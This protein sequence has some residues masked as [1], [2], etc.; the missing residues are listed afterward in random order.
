[1][2]CLNLK[3]KD[4]L[5]Q[6]DPLCILYVRREDKWHEVGRTEQ[7]DNDDSP[8][9]Q[10]KFIVDYFFEERQEVKFEVYDWDKKSEKLTDHDYLGKLKTTLGAIVAARGRQFVA[11]MQKGPSKGG[12]FVIT[13]EEVSTNRDVVR[14][15]L[16]ATGLDKKDTFSKSDPV[17]IISKVTGSG[18]FTP[19]HKTEV[20]NNSLNP[21]W[22][23]FSIS[24]R[25]LCNG[26]YD[27]NLQFE[28][29]DWDSDGK[30]DLIGGFITNLRALSTAT[31]Q[32]KF[33]QCINPKKQSKKNY[34]NSGE[35]FLKYF[36]IERVTSF[37]DYIQAGTNL[38][39]SVAIDFTASN[40]HPR[41]PNSLHF[42]NPKGSNQYTTAI[43]AVGSVIQDYDSDKNFPALG[44]G[45]K[46]PPHGQVSHEF[47]LNLQQDNPFCA[48]VTGILAAYYTSLQHVQ[49]HGPTNFAPIIKHNA[50]LANA[51]QDGRQYFAVLIITDGEITDLD[52]TK[53]AI[54]E[55]SLLPMS[56]IIIGVGNADFRAMEHLDADRGL[57]KAGGRTAVRDIVQFVELRKFLRSD[58]S[59]NKVLLSRHVL[60]ELP[61][62]MVGWMTMKGVKPLRA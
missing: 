25:D 28:V 33:F 43:R 2:A 49:L 35:V 17:L 13:A 61:R 55:A 19:V 44:F 23:P 22:H 36:M 45:A 4:L 21:E 32:N 54:V 34:K 27:R 57:L 31:A 12:Q 24:V 1:M 3:S 50:R 39:F 46:I 47:F 42:R 14:L 58:G 6:S 20:V 10:K 30:S 62:Q 37:M 7:I 48:G 53:A 60:A 52:E 59:Y 8:R 9:W 15:H 38:N 29:F 5:S 56:I 26:D 16:A 18:Q 11:V 51:Y 41:D 40:G